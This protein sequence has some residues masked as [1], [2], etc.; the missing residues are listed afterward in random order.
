[1]VL[2]YDFAVTR[3]RCRVMLAI[4][5]PSPIDDDATES[6]S[7]GDKEATLVVAQ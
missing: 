1:M 6:C 7:D 5:L 4:V 2:P 3:C